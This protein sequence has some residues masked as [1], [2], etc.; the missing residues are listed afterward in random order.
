M[1]NMNEEEIESREWFFIES[2][3]SF[4]TR[5]FSYRFIRIICTIVI[6]LGTSSSFIIIFFGDPRGRAILIGI[7]LILFILI[8]TFAAY[9][10]SSPVRIKM[11]YDYATLPHEENKLKLF[12]R[13]ASTKSVA[14][15]HLRIVWLG[16]SPTGEMKCKFL[17]LHDGRTLDYADVEMRKS[18]LDQLLFNLKSASFPWTYIKDKVIIEGRKEN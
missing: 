16:G 6:I 4:N 8:I 3:K 11:R 9:L 5:R 1:D 12:L 10:E 18:E 15:T 13:F 7:L 14:P 2:D 17:Y